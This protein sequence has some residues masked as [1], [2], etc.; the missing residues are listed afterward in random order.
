[1]Q[2]VFFLWTDG[3]PT[4][5]DVEISDGQKEKEPQRM[6]ARPS[7]LKCWINQGAGTQTSART[8]IARVLHDDDADDAGR[9]IYQW[10]VGDEDPVEP[11]DSDGQDLPA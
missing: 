4:K 10:A 5:G 8:A 6:L 7:R 1:M 11:S 2:K 9:Y 3:R